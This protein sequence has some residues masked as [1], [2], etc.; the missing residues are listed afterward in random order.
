LPQDQRCGGIFE[1]DS[2]RRK[3]AVVAIL[4]LDEFF[5]EGCLTA[6]TRRLST[7]AAA[8]RAAVLVGCRSHAPIKLTH[9]GLDELLLRF[10]HLPTVELQSLYGYPP[11]AEAKKES[12]A[13]RKLK[14]A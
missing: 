13:R 1:S 2:I 7:V 11:S 3:E 4:K 6:Q 5:G 8:R 9:W 10:R 12:E 14:H